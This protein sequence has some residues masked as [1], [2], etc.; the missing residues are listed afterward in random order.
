MR[1][2]FPVQATKRSTYIPYS[3]KK[4]TNT[5]N[6]PQ[7]ATK[8]TLSRFLSFLGNQTGR[9]FRVKT[10]TYVRER[11]FLLLLYLFSSL[12]RDPT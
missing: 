11:K 2:Y 10:L 4:R 9:F 6:D 1:F 3:E 7:T 5:K 12:F 8:K